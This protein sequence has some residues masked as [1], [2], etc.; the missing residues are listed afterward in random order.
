MVNY[1]Q[2][3]NT[4]T[5]LVMM[6]KV[7]EIIDDTAN[8]Y[9]SKT[10][11]DT[12]AN[13][14][15]NRVG[16]NTYSGNLNITGDLSSNNSISNSVTSSTNRY[17]IYYDN[18]GNTQYT[19]LDFNNSSSVI[20]SIKYSNTNKQLFITN[21]GQNALSFDSLNNVYAYKAF[22]LWNADTAAWSQSITGVATSAQYLNKTSDKL[23]STDAVWN[24]A[25]FTSITDS[26]V[27]Q[28]NFALG[29]NFTLQLTTGVSGTF[30]FASPLL[31]PKVGQTGVIEII[32]SGTGG[33]QVAFNNSVWKFD[34]GTAPQIDTAAGRKSVLNYFI[35]SSSE[36]WVN[37]PY[38][39]VR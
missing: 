28:P 14:K 20:Y 16:N 34:S 5:F 35:R 27:I 24:A 2:A 23:L 11:T 15:L 8:N 9:A 3:N 19:Y 7:N 37:M 36:I 4:T 10:Y 13:T 18:T 1:L 6:N 32:Q 38:K 12:Q 25:A 21:G 33:R 26:T 31:N 29:V 30:T 17:K 22:N 39:G